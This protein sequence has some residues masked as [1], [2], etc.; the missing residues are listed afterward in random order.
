MVSASS[1]GR[2]DELLENIDSLGESGPLNLYSAEDTSSSASGNEPLKDEK[3]S[4]SS[5][6]SIRIA[7]GLLGDLV[8]TSMASLHSR[9]RYPSEYM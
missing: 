9:D 6:K 2:I 3:L 8:G 5:P 7:L 4:S 1:L